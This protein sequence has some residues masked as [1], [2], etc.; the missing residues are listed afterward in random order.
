MRLK[1]CPFCGSDGR[2]LMVKGGKDGKI[3]AYQVEC[4]YSKCEVNPT[5]DMF[6]DSH[7]AVRAWNRRFK[8]VLI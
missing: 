7:D 1:K 8:G 5:T 6:R 4:P 3:Y 2:L